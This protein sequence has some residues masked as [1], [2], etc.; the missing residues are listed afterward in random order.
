[1][2]SRYI[3]FLL[4]SMC[5]IWMP[6]LAVA[7]SKKV[8]KNTSS[9]K[10]AVVV[11][12]LFKPVNLGLSTL[13]FGVYTPDEELVFGLEK[14]LYLK[15]M[16][17]KFDFL[18]PAGSSSFSHLALSTVKRSRKIALTNSEHTILIDELS[19]LKKRILNRKLDKTQEDPL[20]KAQIL[21]GD[22]RNAITAITF[23]P[24]NQT[25]VSGTVDGTIVVWDT[26]IERQ[27]LTFKEHDNTITSVAVSADGRY[28]AAGDAD[29]NV[30]LWNLLN[31][32]TL[33]LSGNRHVGEVHTVTFSSDAQTLATGADDG[34][35]LWDIQKQNEISSYKEDF[36]GVK[37]IAFS[38]DRVHLAIGT[39]S[40][41]IF[42]LDIPS[43][44]IIEPIERFKDINSEKKYANVSTAHKNEIL[45]VAFSE[46]GLEMRSLDNTGRY[47]NWDLTEINIEPKSGKLFFPPGPS[48]SLIDHHRKQDK[49]GPIITISEDV[50]KE[51]STTIT[52]TTITGE[53]EDL[54]EVR[55][56]TVKNDAFQSEIYNAQFDKMNRTFTASIPL[57]EGNNKITVLAT[58]VKGNPSEPYSLEIHRQVGEDNTGP[59]VEITEP[60][61]IEN[62]PVKVTSNTRES[63]IR[64]K[65]TDD[66]SGISTV[67]VKVNN[68]IVHDFKETEIKDGEFTATVSLQDGNNAIT[69]TAID[70][71]NNPNET[72]FTITRL[73]PRPIVQPID[74]KVETTEPIKIQTNIDRK[75]EIV[76]PIKDEDNIIKSADN[77]IFVLFKVSPSN[78]IDVNV[79][80][81]Y[82]DRNLDFPCVVEHQGGE[83]FRTTIALTTDQSTMKIN[84]E[85]EGQ[86]VATEQYTI[87]RQS[88][89]PHT[90][91]DE[92]K[93]LPVEPLPTDRLE[94]L[95]IVSL[96]IKNIKLHTSERYSD[97]IREIGDNEVEVS[98]SNKGDIPRIA[99]TTSKISGQ[100]DIIGKTEGPSEGTIKYSI[101]SENK[102]PVNEYGTVK[103]EF[104]LTKQNQKIE[105]EYEDNTL[106]FYAIPPEGNQAD[107]KQK[108][109]INRVHEREG[110]DY[111]LLIAVQDYSKY[112]E[113]DDLEA[114]IADARALKDILE[115]E[116]GFEMYP[117]KGK[118]VENPNRDKILQILSNL[119]KSTNFNE[120]DDQLLI[121]FA[122]H[123]YAMKVN[124]DISKGYFLP[125]PVPEKPLPNPNKTDREDSD[126]FEKL[127]FKLADASISHTDLR[128]WI[129]NIKCNNIL[130]I[131]D[132]CY[133]GV[134]GG[135]LEKMRGAQRLKDEDEKIRNM[136]NN[137]TRQFLT[138]GSNELVLD[139]LPD[140]DHS[141][142]AFQLIEALKKGDENKD[143]IVTFNELQGYFL[144][145][146]FKQLPGV[147]QT[148]SAGTFSNK[149]KSGGEFLL[150]KRKRR[151]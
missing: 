30:K 52:E 68:T 74:T 111:A 45:S 135:G 14:I 5:L 138:S 17:N 4:I 36:S 118:V 147:D 51:V 20:A 6:V 146:R 33:P 64:G 113:W 101:N 87:I 83:F 22:K 123:G 58:D 148:P 125:K 62:L 151:E 59:T 76:T 112:S 78:N 71:R 2:K 133:S 65:V 44:K 144:P 60:V 25:L 85:S 93:P 56:I 42:L 8:G 69:I 126:S 97:G 49:D 41:E 143:S 73:P 47:L 150:W 109:I 35:T 110:K 19:E 134:F 104:Q 12:P 21:Y 46:N 11:I 139:K 3:M 55:L 121:F 92:P 32:K 61:I 29:G 114:P 77:P 115:D 90:P 102:I 131:M 120:H 128:F 84:V 18:E 24:D 67:K 48:S 119:A 53:I 140:D 9:N 34:L 66:K 82:A 88:S 54:N 142:F 149:H 80:I 136:L 95:K 57:Q 129:D 137:G 106:T 132:T 40:G 122:G 39:L 108:L 116:Y 50:K 98:F 15:K 31:Q 107:H 103:H 27:F 91:T 89:T 86:T 105:L 79:Q 37:C 38:P 130:V 70:N 100:I 94:P 16:Q 28:L 13:S 145:H 7:Q 1:M 63:T 72:K 96:R 10:P 23:S 117:E 141:P 99:V 81:R 75:I 43:E 127:E 124:K 26:E